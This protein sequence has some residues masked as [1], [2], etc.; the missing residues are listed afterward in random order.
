MKALV[1]FGLAYIAVPLSSVLGIQT[2]PTVQEAAQ[3]AVEDPPLAV[4]EEAPAQPEPP[5]SQKE[6]NKEIVTTYTV[7]T[8]GQ[9]QVPA[10][11]EIV[12]HES[13]FNNKAQNP[14]STAFGL[15]QFLDSTWQGTGIAKTDDPIQQAQALMIYVKNRYGTPQQ[16]LHF[17]KQAGWY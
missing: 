6:L 17:R 12:Q 11:L 15:A 3:A 10:M 2:L 5:K 7:A 8:F 14:H 4:V 13:G 16:A 9:D 1:M